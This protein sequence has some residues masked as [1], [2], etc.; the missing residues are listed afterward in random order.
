MN[1]KWKL[2]WS[3]LA[4]REFSNLDRAVAIQITKKIEQAAQNPAH[5]FKR[6]V[7]REE[8]KLRIGD[9]R[10]IVFLNHSDN[11]VQIQR[12]GHRKNIYDL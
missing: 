12:I 5:Y 8:Y 4:A 1:L 2:R 10:V 3:P 7:D 9:Y 11:T 6:L